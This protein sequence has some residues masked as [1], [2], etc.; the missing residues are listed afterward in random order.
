LI[1]LENRM[2]SLWLNQTVQ[3]VFNAYYYY[4]SSSVGSHFARS[5]A[6]IFFILTSVFLLILI[7]LIVNFYK[8]FQITT[9]IFRLGH[10]IQ[11]AAAQL[12]T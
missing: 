2:Y 5:R 4:F 1:F 3:I 10:S 9:S 12:N 7:G 8:I 6:I 11:E